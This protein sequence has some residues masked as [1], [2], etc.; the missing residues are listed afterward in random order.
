MV[1][2]SARAAICRQLC[3][4]AKAS[5]PA[6]PCEVNLGAIVAWLSKNKSKSKSNG[7]VEID[8]EAGAAIA[9]MKHAI[10]N[11]GFFVVQP[12]ASLV[13]VIPRVYDWSERFHKLDDS[14]KQ[15]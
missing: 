10:I 7:G 3:T 5:S 15:K 12:P 11:D 6:Q 9:N 14:I 2:F 4:T 8:G 1:F 13:P